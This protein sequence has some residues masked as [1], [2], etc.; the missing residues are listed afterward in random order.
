MSREETI[1]ERV[2]AVLA[3]VVLLL[4]SWLLFMALSGAVHAQ[5]TVTM[6]GQYKATSSADLTWIASET[7]GVTYTAYR[8]PTNGPYLKIKD[9]LACC[10][11]LDTT[12]PAK[13][14][15][16]YTMTAVDEASNESVPTPETCVQ[17]P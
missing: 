10:E 1:L 7:P 8:G 5:T 9:M 6:K 17:V 13:Q 3:V 2:S 12:V 15:S 16:C 11:Y 14:Q 4:C